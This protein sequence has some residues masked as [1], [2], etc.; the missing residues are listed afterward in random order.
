MALSRG[1]LK[2]QVLRLLMKT[3]QYPGFY[4]DAL[5]NDAL[6]EAFDFVAVEMFI[7][8]EGWTDK[9]AYYDTTAGQLAVPIRESMAMLREVRYLYGDIY[10]PMTYDTE[11]SQKQYAETSG[12]RQYAYTYRIVDNQLFFNP[13]L[14]EGGTK[15]LQIEYTDFPKSLMS[16]DD[17]IEPQFNRAFTNFI[18]YRTASILAASVEKFVI[19]WQAIENSWYMKMKE[20]V[21][22]RNLQATQ[23][24]EF[25]DY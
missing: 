3:A 12:V 4:T 14:A 2:G 18:K 9:I 20:V 22:K 8:G 6:Q 5:I 7:A 24:R 17:Q 23:V 11:N 13:C 16:D 21:V 15:Y 1:E 10:I 25:G 19:P